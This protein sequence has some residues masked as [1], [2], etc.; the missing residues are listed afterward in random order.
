MLQSPINKLKEMVAKQ[1]IDKFQSTM[2][3]LNETKELKIE[4]IKSI[5]A[6]I[7]RELNTTTK[8]YNELYNS[9][10]SQLDESSSY[11]LEASYFRYLPPPLKANPKNKTTFSEKIAALKDNGTITDEKAKSFLEIGE[12]QFKYKV[13]LC[14]AQQNLYYSKLRQNPNDEESLKE[15]INSLENNPQLCFKASAEEPRFLHDNIKLNE[16]FSPQMLSFVFKEITSLRAKNWN[17]EP[18][19]IP[20]I[21]ESGLPDNHPQFKGWDWLLKT[22]GK[23]FGFIY[24]N[25]KTHAR[26]FVKTTGNEFS[27]WFVSNYLL[28]LGLKFPESKVL[29]DPA[30]NIYFATYDMSRKY[31]KNQIFKEKQFQTFED[32][33]RGGSTDMIRTYRQ[34]TKQDDRDKAKDPKLIEASVAEI[35]KNLSEKF[36]PE[37]QHSF[38]KIFIAGYIFNLSDLGSHQGNLG[39]L[40]VQKGNK[41]P[42]FKI[43]LIDFQTHPYQISDLSADNLFKKIRDFGINM[44]PV[45]KEML[46]KLSDED[47]LKA[48][49]DV[50]S[51]KI[52]SIDDDVLLTQATTQRTTIESIIKKSFDDTC[53]QIRALK[54][55]GL[56]QETID[57]ALQNAN[58]EYKIF[59]SNI[60]S[61]RNIYEQLKS[62]A[63]ISDQSKQN[64][65][66]TNK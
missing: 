19:L 8:K 44:D 56:P 5:I 45:F 47:L 38:A 32:I 59:E 24:K 36:T 51:P 62:Q 30:G 10:K 12:R 53:E 23:E 6:M 2:L 39:F 16:I 4:D 29:V 18:W 35:N 25:P 31:A 65:R 17:V 20:F 26:W 28:Q 3:N 46:G 42:Y 54:V 43:G 1:E 63:K 15:F 50:I 33:F 37:A 66:P 7:T 64:L 49:E 11:D 21:V 52:R 13:L 9:V 34:S 48:L 22:A 55:K 58:E 14:I 40:R 60:G 57:K 41:N 27:E 61:L